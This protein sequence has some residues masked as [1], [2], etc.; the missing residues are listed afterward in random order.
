MP[1]SIVPER[2]MQ[3]SSQVNPALAQP[4]YSTHAAPVEEESLKNIWHVLRKRKTWIGCFVLAGVLLAILVCLLLKNQYES[5]ATVQVGKDMTL[6]VELASNAS[7]PPTLSDSDT[8]TDIAT[9]MAVLEDDNTALAV[10]QDLNLEKYKPFAFEP[11]ILGWINGNNDRIRAESGR[12]LSQAP[13]RRERLLAIFARKLDVKNPPDT[14]L[15]T[16]SFLN[17]DRDLA[18]TI[19]NTV[20]REY[21]KFESAEQSGG[22]GIRALQL[23]LDGLRANMDEAQKNLADYEQQTGLNSLLLKSMGQGSGGGTYTHIPVLDRLDLL[24]QTL[25]TAEANRIGKEAIYN[26]TK[27]HNSDVVSGLATS[28]IAA[29]ATSSVVT[30][31]NGLELLQTLRQEQ[32]SLTL[33]YSA[34][35]TTYGAKSPRILELQNQITNLNKQIS[36]E[37]EQINLR[38]RND[39]EMARQ[40]EEGLRAAFDQQKSAASKMNQSAVSLEVLAQQAA[41]S[42]QLYEALNQQ[43]Q[44]ANVQAGLRA[45]NIRVTNP[46]RP[47]STPKR[48]N[49]PIY[50]PI[51]LALGL[52][53]GIPTAFIREHMDETV[54]SILQVD[55]LTP[56]PVLASIPQIKAETSKQLADGGAVLADAGHESSPLVL[57]PRSATAEAYR[58]LRTSAVRVSAGR[59]M[60]TLLVTSPL[61]GEGKTSVA[62][63]TA[64]AFAQAGEQVLLVDADL[65]HPRLHHHF[66]VTQSPGLSNVVSDG[67][68]LDAVVHK[69]S[70]IPHL[71]L[72]TAGDSKSVP[73]QLLGSVKFEE[74]LHRLKQSY[75]TIVLDSPPMLLMTDAR[76]LAD[77][78]D[79]ILAVI[80]CDVT[81]Q[82]AVE[83]MLELLERDGSRAL[84]LV[85]N[86][87][88]PLS[89]DYY[90]AYGHNVSDKYFEE[91]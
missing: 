73:S 5:V 71:S 39:Y 18:A 10:I 44:E 48:P 32:A 38:A 58:T 79:A 74:V 57:R 1:V 62:Y 36:D 53:L 15:I 29:L 3:R 61:I 75:S 35:V 55:T 23:R 52:L 2:G 25:T 85:I 81:N 68:Q 86:G 13:A 77:K 89:V 34:A 31:G 78:S 6:Q 84:G 9:H 19:S 65:H 17:P 40:N 20:V 83:R 42:R 43:I 87:V 11:T 59:K 72:L 69:H 60:Q 33:Q 28:S 66:G 21:V 26:L 64:I 12:P 91:S 16:V 67:L 63:N 50:I 27:T 88:D 82:I 41:S 30:Q 76:L 8:K 51:G 24:N 45:T 54:K 80:R 47:S 4:S 22:E 90:R 37:L 49:P 46:A 14:R 7:A 56:I 70:T